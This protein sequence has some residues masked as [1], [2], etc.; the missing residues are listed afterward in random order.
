M[1]GIY[2]TISRADLQ[3]LLGA[4]CPLEPGGMEIERVEVAR[5]KLIA[6]NP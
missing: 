3:G 5:I 2:Y 1:P 4:D 6:P